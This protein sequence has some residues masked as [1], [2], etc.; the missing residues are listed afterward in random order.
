MF[1]YYSTQR[2]ITPGALPAEPKLAA[3]QNFP[4]R[5]FVSAIGREAWGYVDFPCE[6][7][8][9]DIREYE[10]TP[11][12]ADTGKADLVYKVLAAMEAYR[13]K[14][15]YNGEPDHPDF[16]I[17]MCEAIVAE[18]FGVRNRIEWTD[19]IQAKGLFDYKG[20]YKEQYKALIKS[21]RET[22]KEETL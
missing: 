6:L 3:V 17:R 1:R 18:A 19:A 8:E 7:S 10:L 21:I 2:P 16:D 14:T 9:K 5:Q 22:I 12:P 20:D 11:E 4:E 15:A 13:L